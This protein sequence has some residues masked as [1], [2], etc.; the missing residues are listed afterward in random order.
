MNEKIVKD[1]LSLFYKR[2]LNITVYNIIF[3]SLVKGG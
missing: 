2:N 3:F 1:N